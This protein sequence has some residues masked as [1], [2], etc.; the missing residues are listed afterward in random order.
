MAPKRKAQVPKST[1]A[2]RGKRAKAGDTG[3]VRVLTPVQGIVVD[4]RAAGAEPE[5]VTR[6]VGA[7]S[8]EPTR[9]ADSG[10]S[11]GTSMSSTAIHETRCC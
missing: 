10:T 8:V 9:V 1:G 3:E 4:A 6:D 7:D 5:P 11:I 2:T